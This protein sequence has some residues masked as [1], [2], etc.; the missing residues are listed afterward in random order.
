M[1]RPQ[2]EP[3][4]PTEIV[5]ALL[6]YLRGRGV[7]VDAYGYSRE[8]EDADEASVTFGALTALLDESVRVLGEQ[9]LA[10]RLP[11]ELPLRRH[12]FGDIAVRASATVED[13]LDRLARYVALFVPWSEGSIERAPNE[14][15]LRLRTK[16][17]RRAPSRALHELLLAYAWQHV[18]L[19]AS[20]AIVPVRAWV[21]HARPRD[22]AP[23]HRTFGT[24]ELSFGC[25]DDGFAITSSDAEVPMR[26]VDPRL[27]A[28]AETL[29]E[30]AL[31]ARIV[32]RRFAD[33]VL[34]KVEALFPEAPIDDVAA[35]LHMSARTLQRRLEEDGAR[36]SE[37][38]DQARERLA[39]TLVADP[40]VTMGELAARLGFADPASFNRAFKRWTGMPPGAFRRR[41]S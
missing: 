19:G 2:K 7:E 9:D 25:E 22:L 26:G 32:P 12:G 33:L 4:L 38:V 5:P 39:R 17:S 41:S 10:L 34:A 11:N 16:S 3:P 23:M 18:A 24:R 37:I 31:Q 36:Y 29:A 40:S 8:I 27:V 6:R 1:A 21:I 13:A 14:L 28:T 35:A 20:R 30:G 15:T